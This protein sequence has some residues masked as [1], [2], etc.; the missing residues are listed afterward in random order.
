MNFASIAK[1]HDG[2]V[3]TVILTGMGADGR[4]GARLLNSR[5]S[6]IWA[7]DEASCVVYGMPG[8]AQKKG[9][10]C[11]ETSLQLIPNK[12]VNF[13]NKLNL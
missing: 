10:V 4:D 8:E 13:F 1:N 2:N 6:T 5:G 3:L 7:Q 11:L 12:I 9:A